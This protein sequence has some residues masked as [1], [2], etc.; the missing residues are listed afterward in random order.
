[1]VSSKFVE[2]YRKK[3]ISELEGFPKA[4]HAFNLLSSNVILNAYYISGNR[5]AVDRLSYNDHGIVHAHIA[6]LNAIK[7]LKILSKHISPNVISEG[8]GTLDDSLVV[9]I[10]SAFLHDIGHIVHRIWHPSYSAIFGKPF[11]EE[12]VNSLYPDNLQKRIDIFSLILHGIM[13]H[14]DEIPC[15]TIEAGAVKVGDGCDLTEGRSRLPASKGKIDIHSISA[16]AIKTVDIIEGKN[17]PVC[18]RIEMENPAGVF[19]VEQ[20]LGKKLETSGL[21][22]YVE[23]ELFLN[24]KPLVL[25][26]V[27]SVINHNENSVFKSSSE[28]ES[29]FPS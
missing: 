10:S 8:I 24:D 18:I 5:M 16:L 17:S 14:D 19:Q 7:V 3:I 6:T 11:V 22:P 4:L 28:E 15:L 2:K 21:K 9:V 26:E 13:A 29:E 20:V 23:F 27:R 25:S 1:M 12:V